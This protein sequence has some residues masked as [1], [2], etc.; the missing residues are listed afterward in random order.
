[1]KASLNGREYQQLIDPNVDLASEER[2]VF[3]LPE[4][5]IPL[6]TPL[7]KQLGKE[8]DEMDE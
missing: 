6:K 7:R 1:V 4:W 3:S 8:N 5:I 2:P